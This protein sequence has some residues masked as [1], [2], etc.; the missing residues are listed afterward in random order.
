MATPSIPTNYWLQQA[1]G[2]CYLQWD[3]VAG[4]TSYQVQRSLDGVT[5]AI[6][7]SPVLNEYED[8]TV[9]VGVYYYYK[10]ASTNTSGTGPYTDPQTAVP[11]LAGEM[12][13]E[14][15]GRHCLIRAD[16]LH[17]GAIQLPD[18]NRKINDS[19]NSLYDLLIT[20][21]EDY[22]KAPNVLF[23]SINNQQN[24]PVPNGITPFLNDSMQSFVPEPIYKLMGVDLS[25]GSQ[26]NGWL[27]VDKFM[28]IDRNRYVYPNS[29]SQIYGVLNL[30]YRWLGTKIEFIPIPSANQIIRL[31]YIPKL[32]QLI[33]PH[34]LTTTN[35]SGWLE[36]VILDVAIKILAEEESDITALAMQRQ[37]IKDRIESAAQNKD[38]GKPDTISDVRRDGSNG[39]SGPIGGF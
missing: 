14:E 1:N 35:I 12:C 37:D 5:Y 4:A 33:K 6:V 7:A 19:L 32:R 10:V 31:Q 29:A 20:A 28:F 8:T 25:A 17:S 39:Y 24:Y 34:D 21:Y 23:T 11:A 2:T 26:N 27:T 9:T 22:F 30:Q 36:Y 38:V 18:L 16:R 3:I 13:L 15:L